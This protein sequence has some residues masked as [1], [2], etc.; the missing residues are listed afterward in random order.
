MVRK[1]ALSTLLDSALLL[2]TPSVSAALTKIVGGLEES[3]G[4]RRWRWHLVLSAKPRYA[5][6]RAQM[7]VRQPNV[8]DDDKRGIAQIPKAAQPTTEAHPEK[9]LPRRAHVA[10][11]TSCR[12]HG[13]S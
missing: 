12:R 11:E 7:D 1:V 10:R 2:V 9:V 5:R 6:P 4:V 3:F 8:N 13:L